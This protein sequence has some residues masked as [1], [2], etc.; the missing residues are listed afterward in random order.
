MSYHSI[1]IHR[2]IGTVEVLCRALGVSVSGYYTWRT[3]EPS[4]RQQSDARLLP[5]IRTVYQAGW[6]LY[7]ISRVHAALRQQD[8]RCSSKR[9]A[10]L[11]RQ[12]GIHFRRRSKRRV[13]TTDSQHTRPHALNLLKRDFS[14]DA[15]NEKWVGNIVGIW[16][17]QSWLYLAALL[18]TYSRLIVGW[19]LSG[20][21]DEA[22]METAFRMALAQRE[23]PQ[24]TS[25]I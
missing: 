2:Q 3:R 20:H 7:G 4:Q 8:V 19:A 16:A 12:A 24:P 15:P 10:R 9:V 14:A 22:L 11:M 6:G 23:L 21:R 25:L 13:R 18:D 5:H 1:E 17:D